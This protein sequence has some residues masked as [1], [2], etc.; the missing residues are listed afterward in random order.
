MTPLWRAEP[1][2]ESTFGEDV[3]CISRLIGEVCAEIPNAT[4]ISGYNLVPHLPDFFSDR[5]LHPND[6]GFALY[7][8]NLLGKIL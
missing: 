4:V 7:A 3:R 8:Q 5:R 6:I 1:P 2:T